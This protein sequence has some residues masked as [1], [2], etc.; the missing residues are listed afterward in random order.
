MVS[1]RD[2]IDRCFNDTPDLSIHSTLSRSNFVE[3]NEGKSQIA[4]NVTG[5]PWSR[6]HL[7]SMS[8]VD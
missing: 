8:N 3:E 2:S 5:N 6:I 7:V 1:Y 4:E